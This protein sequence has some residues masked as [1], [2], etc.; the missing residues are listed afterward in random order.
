MWNTTNRDQFHI[1]KRREKKR[2]TFQPNLTETY[3]QRRDYCIILQP[4]YVVLQ[5]T[6]CRYKYVCTSSTTIPCERSYRSTRDDI[7]GHL[8]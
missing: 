1:K 5:S 4:F 6:V 8:C 7:K 3:D 2:K